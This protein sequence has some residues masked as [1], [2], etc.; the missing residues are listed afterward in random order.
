MD[1]IENNF[2]REDAFSFQLMLYCMAK[3]I[4]FKNQKIKLFSIL[5]DS[6]SYHLSCEP[7]FSRS[8][9]L[10]LLSENF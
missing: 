10:S 7:N 5:S 3:N 4:K 1:I 9:T 6:S 2:S 8:K